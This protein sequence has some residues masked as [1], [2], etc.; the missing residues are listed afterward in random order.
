MPGG[1]NRNPHEMREIGWMR[2]NHFKK[3]GTWVFDNDSRRILVGKFKMDMRFVSVI[4]RD[5][6]ARLHIQKLQA[7]FRGC[8][9]RKHAQRMR[10]APRR[11]FIVGAPSG[12]VDGVYQIVRRIINGYPAWQHQI[13]P[14]YVFTS[15]SGRWFVGGT[16]AA[17]LQF[18]CEDGMLAARRILEHAMPHDVPVG[19]W[20]HRDSQTARWSNIPQAHVLMH[21]VD[22]PDLVYVHGPERFR[23]EYRRLRRS[24]LRVDDEQQH[25]L[26]HSFDAL[27][28]VVWASINGLPAWRREKKFAEEQF[29]YSGLTSARWFLGESAEQKARFQSDS[30]LFRS[31]LPHRGLLPHKVRGTKPFFNRPFQGLDT[32]WMQWYDD[33]DIQID[34]EVRLYSAILRI[35]RWVRH[36]FYIRAQQKFFMTMEIARKL[37]EHMETASSECT[38]IA[39]LEEELFEDPAERSKFEEELKE[40]RKLLEAQE[41]LFRVQMRYLHFCEGLERRHEA[42]AT[43]IQTHHRMMMAQREL[44]RRQEMPKNKPLEGM[45]MQEQVAVFE[46]GWSESTWSP[47]KEVRDAQPLQRGWEWLTT[48]QQSA[49]QK[50][51]FESSDFQPVTIE[52]GDTVDSNHPDSRGDKVFIR[53]IVFPTGAIIM[54]E[55]RLA[56]SLTIGSLRRQVSKR[57]HDRKVF[58]VKQADVPQ[59]DELDVQHL[60]SNRAADQLTMEKWGIKEGDTIVAFVHGV[61]KL[62]AT[63]YPM[64][65]TCGGA[66]AALRS[67]GR[68]VT[69]G[70]WNRGGDSE[71]VATLLKGGVEEV[72][73]TSRAFLAKK[74]DGRLVAWGD[75]RYG[76]DF[77]AVEEQLLRGGIRQVASTRGAFAVVTTERSLVA[78]GDAR[79]GGDCTAAQRAAGKRVFQ[80]YSN[81]GAFAARCWKGELVTWGNPSCGGDSSKHAKWLTEGIRKVWSGAYAFAAQNDKGHVF[82]WGDEDSGGD[83]SSV[84]DLLRPSRH[85]KEKDLP[86]AI[87]DVV[88]TEE[89]FAALRVDG[90]VIVWGNPKAGGS[91]TEFG[92][93]FPPGALDSNVLK[94]VGNRQAF[95][96]I[97][98]DG[99]IHSWGHPRDG[100]D[101][102][103]MRQR[104]AS[105]V[106]SVHAAAQAFAAVKE[107]GTVVA[108]GDPASGGDLSLVSDELEKSHAV[109]PKISGNS[110]AFTA[111]VAWSGREEDD[112][113]V[114]AWGDQR[115]GGDSTQAVC[116]IA[117]RV[118]GRER[119]KGDF[120][121]VV[122]TGRAFAALDLDGTVA[123]WGD[124]ES[125]GDC[126]AVREALL[127]GVPQE[128]EPFRF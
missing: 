16:E 60:A 23:G 25:L 89:A 29:L 127:K 35:Q 78:W 18:Q 94:L 72:F 32:K 3:P 81:T 33:G 37:R 124:P 64:L 107:D 54:T 7:W 63:A 73:A 120:V 91:F 105:G 97:K 113:G 95:V 26:D 65:E 125:G 79:S 93:Q 47:D 40:A 76:G 57:L 17:A 34:G 46:L 84:R 59:E 102:S 74:V 106:V 121:Q 119:I 71:D 13:K 30:G 80:I 117:G 122:E 75:A 87:R 48:E 110:A 50:L 15:P 10:D 5:D 104:L 85:T 115:C 90:S 98:A 1:K 88:S 86:P 52:E 39:Y 36:I 69:W 126:E 108:W 27:Q 21:C 112:Q 109:L 123:A 68:V 22:V 2:F 116:N 44:K 14:L 41:R 24:D 49:A 92:Q 101:S 114:V 19:K 100:G 28:E 38:S 9:G 45:S 96:A 4:V 6:Q 99:S 43:K 51:G 83:C 62:Y 128:I 66:I 53:G 56:L 55:S 77:S 58:L 118:V 12:E 103:A 42:A 11:L 8:L 31:K 82:A 61:L 20:W 70:A 111:V 67:D